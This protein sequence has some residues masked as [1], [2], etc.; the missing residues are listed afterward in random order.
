MRA[1]AC[2]FDSRAL[3]CWSLAET[4]DS[5][6]AWATMSKSKLPW[7]QLFT[8]DVLA[9]EELKSCS[10]AA[11]GLWVYMLSL[12]HRSVRR[13]YL[14]QANGQPWN[15]DQLARMTGCSTQEAAHLTQELLTAGV[16]SA[17][18]DGIIYSR[19]M[20]K[21]AAISKVRSEVGKRGAVAKHLPQQNP[22]KQ[23]GKRVGKPPGKPLK[24]D[25]LSSPS[26]EEEN[27]E[28]PFLSA[29]GVRGDLPQQNPGKPPDP[30]GDA[31][32]P[33]SD[34][35]DEDL[36]AAAIRCSETWRSRVLARY[37]EPL[38]VCVATFKAM[39]KQGHSEAVI[40]AAIPA[41]GT[42]EWLKSFCDRL[43]KQIGV[44]PGTMFTG[45][46]AAGTAA[47]YLALIQRG[48]EKIA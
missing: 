46:A 11:R 7:M 19:G 40:L 27:S 38:K 45:P 15:L 17:T 18:D 47:N 37:P 13:G 12:M 34:E 48:K 28:S 30:P 9:D 32:T 44:A 2:G 21:Q 1:P 42:R 31:E 43:D 6:G 25:S 10:L 36:E 33:A 22:G 23:G 8:G 26:P 39:L 29:R 5:Q 41:D 20:V 35:A 14:C 3:Y 24:Y 16:F 4:M